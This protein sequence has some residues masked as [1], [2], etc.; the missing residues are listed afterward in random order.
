MTIINRFLN[1]NLEIIM[2]EG[3]ICGKLHVVACGETHMKE[4]IYEVFTRAGSPEI[5]I[6]TTRARS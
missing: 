1:L 2:N 3:Q 4:A 5:K 6:E